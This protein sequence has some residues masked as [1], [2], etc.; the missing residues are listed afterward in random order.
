MRRVKE[1]PAWH[2]QAIEA[3]IHSPERLR[4]LAGALRSG[5]TGWRI[6]RWETPAVERR[7]RW[8]A[9]RLAAAAVAASFL[10]LATTDPRAFVPAVVAATAIA[11][12]ALWRGE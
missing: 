1:D 10:V 7:R 9:R 12:V 4:R 6:D 11:A 2:G 5:E 3:T 8:Q